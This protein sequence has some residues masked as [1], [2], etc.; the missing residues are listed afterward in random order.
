MEAAVRHA[1]VLGS[2]WRERRWR[3]SDRRQ[4]RY[5][6]Q[7]WVRAVTGVCPAGGSI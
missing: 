3:R 7:I 2:I 4:V 6:V 5:P 1:A